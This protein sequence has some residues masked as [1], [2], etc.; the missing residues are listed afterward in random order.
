MGE[1]AGLDKYNL[2]YTPE[3]F[4][5]RDLGAVTHVKNQKYCG[6]CW[7]FSTSGDIEGTHFL[8]TGN[9]TVLSEQQLVACDSANDGCDGGWMYAAMQYVSNFGVMVEASSYMY[10]GIFMDYEMPTPT[11]D[12]DLL[13][14]KLEKNGDNSAHIEGFKFVAMGAEYEELMKVYLVKNGPLSLAINA[15]GMEYYVHGIV[16][17]ETIAGSDH[18][19]LLVAYG[20]QEGIPYWV[21]KNSWST[22]WGEDGYYRIEMGSNHCGVANMVQHSVYKKA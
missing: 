13:N 14:D 21:I 15:A 20:S 1:F 12:V 22:P 6:S 7:T 8:A 16:G 3:D 17:C 10:K 2:T 18:C 5:W 19:V 4:D 9:L 11:C